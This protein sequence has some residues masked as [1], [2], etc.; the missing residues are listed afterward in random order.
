MNHTIVSSIIGP[1]LGRLP[2]VAVAPS[3]FFRGAADPQPLQVAIITAGVEQ[4]V[5]LN[6]IHQLTQISI[7]SLRR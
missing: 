5:P 4:C 2:M 6:M 3:T 1:L 7:A